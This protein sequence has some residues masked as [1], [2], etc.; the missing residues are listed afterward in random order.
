[1]SL[2]H[3]PV[4]TPTLFQ[5]SFWTRVSWHRKIPG[6]QTTASEQLDCPN[7]WRWLLGAGGVVKAHDLQFLF[8]LGAVS[9]WET[10]C[11]F[12]MDLDVGSLSHSITEWT[13][14]NLL[15]FDGSLACIV[16]PT[17]VWLCRVFFFLI[18]DFLFL[19]NPH[20][21]SYASNICSIK[22]DTP[23]WLDVDMTL[24]RT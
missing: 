6:H 24:D 8:R 13:F 11:P 16:F 5:F 2:I 23:K 4:T 3:H 7:V 22:L 18:F 15:S 20:H 19:P 17:P 9:R 21:L 14:S 1:M 12:C 10:I